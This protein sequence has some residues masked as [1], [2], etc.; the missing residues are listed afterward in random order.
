[1]NQPAPKPHWLKRL[2]A[3]T[4]HR[5]SVGC[6]DCVK[7]QREHTENLFASYTAPYGRQEIRDGKLVITCPS[8]QEEFTE[9]TD[10][11]TGELVSDHYGTHYQIKHTS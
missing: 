10:S 6:P 9:V 4:H 8:C 3:S 2:H 1:M 5:P 11:R 7:A